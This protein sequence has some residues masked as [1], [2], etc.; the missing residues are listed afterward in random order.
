MFRAIVAIVRTVV[1]WVAGRLGL[2]SSPSFGWRWTDQQDLHG[3]LPISDHV[4]RYMQAHS[5]KAGQLAVCVDG[6]LEF[7]AAYTWAEE[8]YAVTKTTSLMRIASC[9]KTHTTAA[10]KKLVDDGRLSGSDKVFD[11]L[12]IGAGSHTPRDA[13]SPDIT[14]EQLIAHTGGW[15]YRTRASVN[16]PLPP[17]IDPVFDL[18]HIGRVLGL[19]QP[20]NKRQFATYV[21]ERIGLDFDPGSQEQYSNIGYVLLGMVVEAKTGGAPFID[22]VNNELL[23]PANIDHAFV[24]ATRREHHRSEEVRYEEHLSG[25]DATRH[26]ADL[27]PALLPY[28][29][30]GGMTELMDSGGGLIT[31][32]QALARVVSMFNNKRGSLTEPGGRTPGGPRFGGM[33]GTTACT[34]SFDAKLGSRC[35]D[36]AFIFN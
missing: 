36:Y 14:V 24:G 1:A 29:G 8:A 11:L 2:S 5:I 9:S 18:K 7:S 32:A 34:R 19:D 31:T 4:K 13:S 6:T 30:F 23:Q 25:P 22:F 17:A 35:Y 26:P 27:T 20:P 10:I 15:N 12:G 28:G 21:F 16:P 33:P 3:V